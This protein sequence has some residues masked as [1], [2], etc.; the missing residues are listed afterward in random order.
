MNGTTARH[1]SRQ[2]A[3]VTRLIL[4][5]IAAALHPLTLADVMMAD[6]GGATLAPMPTV[7]KLQ[8]FCEKGLLESWYDHYPICIKVK[9]H[10]PPQNVY[11]ITEAGRQLLAE[12]N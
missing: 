7:A 1:D 12:N 3:D 11:S 2:E 4:T 6:D 9:G 8:E 10:C 5:R